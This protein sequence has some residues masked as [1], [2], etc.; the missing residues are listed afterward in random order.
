[1]I[2]P[3]RRFVG[4]HRGAYISMREAT[5][6]VPFQLPN[7]LIRVGFLLSAIKFFDTGLQAMMAYIRSDADETSVMS[8]RH[9]ELAAI[10]LFP[11]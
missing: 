3:L 10:Y 1:M 6:H 4:H 9:F 7:K 2:Y 11:F 5:V 8:K